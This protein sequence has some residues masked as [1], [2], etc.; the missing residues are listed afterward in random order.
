MSSV[1]TD[2]A[3]LSGRIMQ[4]KREGSIDADL[5]KF[6]PINIKCKFVK[7]FSLP[8]LRHQHYRRFATGEYLESRKDSRLT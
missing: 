1:I 5:R 2:T 8:E 7:A 3:S 6:T 4:N